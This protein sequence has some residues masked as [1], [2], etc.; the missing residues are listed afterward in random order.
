VSLDG[1][2]CGLTCRSAAA[3]MAGHGLAWPGV[4][5][6]WL[7]EI[8]LAR[9]MVEWPQAPM[10]PRIANPRSGMSQGERDAPAAA[11]GPRGTAPRYTPRRADRV[12]LGALAKKEIPLGMPR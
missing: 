12:R 6:R 4:C 1:A 9:L 10:R 11:D 7:P 3:R 5:G 8:W 2:R